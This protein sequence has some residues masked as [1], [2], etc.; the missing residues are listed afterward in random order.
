MN[1]TI[2]QPIDRVLQSLQ[3]LFDGSWVVA[4]SEASVLTPFWLT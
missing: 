4:T 3:V 1:A 2:I